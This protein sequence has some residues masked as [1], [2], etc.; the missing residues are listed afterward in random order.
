MS[1][2]AHVTQPAP[3][4]AVTKVAL[5]LRGVTKSW[6]AHTI[7]DAVDL[8]LFGGQTCWLGG[9]NGAG[10]TTLLRIAS[11][12]IAPDA[13]CVSAGGCDPVRDRRVFQ[14]R[15]GFLTAGDRGLYARLSPR[16]HLNLWGSL[17]LMPGDER[18]PA[19]EAALERFELSEFADR[20]VDRLSLG[21]RQR[22]RLALTFMHAPPIVLLDEPHTSLDGDGLVL[23]ARAV[24]ETAERGGAALWCSPAGLDVP[25][26]FDHRL[27]LEDGRLVEA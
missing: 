13:G 19:V 4:H 9:A 12:L 20:R 6:G 8:E 10:K 26:E 11:G 16:R 18:R 22:L 15:V 5:E 2:L 25:Y 21:Q 14:H 1:T 3:P 17:L 7:L 24:Q 23:L 27:H